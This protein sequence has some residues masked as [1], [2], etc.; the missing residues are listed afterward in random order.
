MGL[1]YGTWPWMREFVNVSRLGLPAIKLWAYD[2]SACSDGRYRCPRPMTAR[3]FTDHQIFASRKQPVQ[4][5]LS[6]EIG[7]IM[8]GGATQGLNSV[9]YRLALRHS[10]EL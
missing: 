9:Y 8:L 1:Y 6:Q 10:K 5:L 2:H 7:Q 4:R 3:S